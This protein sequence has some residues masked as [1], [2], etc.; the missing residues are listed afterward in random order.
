MPENMHSQCFLIFLDFTLQSDRCNKIGTQNVV[1]NEHS[2]YK[3]T[4]DEFNPI[5]PN[6]AFSARKYFC[7]VLCKL[8]EN[9]LPDK[10]VK[11][12]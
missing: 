9:F 1:T 4:G 6:I 8:T 12:R 2:T 11:R 10:I 5:L 7:L 3:F